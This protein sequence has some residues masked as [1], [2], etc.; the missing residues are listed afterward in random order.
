MKEDCL[1]GDI[2][3]FHTYTSYSRVKDKTYRCLEWM[4]FNYTNIYRN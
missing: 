3:N 1:A 2:I 4:I